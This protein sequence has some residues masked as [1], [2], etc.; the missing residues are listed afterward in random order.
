MK[1]TTFAITLL[2][3]IALAALARYTASSHAASQPLPAQTR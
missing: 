1:P 3:I 2:L